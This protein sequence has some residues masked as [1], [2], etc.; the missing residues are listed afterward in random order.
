[1][2]PQFNV[3]KKQK[4][5]L[6]ILGSILL[7][8]LFV[9]TIASLLFFFR[10]PL[11]KGILEKQLE[12][13]T[14]IRVAIGTLDY[15]LFPLRIEAGSTRFQT[16]IEATEV[17]V[18][19]GR[20]VLRGDIHRLRKKEKPYFDTILA[21]DVRMLADVRIARKKI[22]FED[23]L[24]GL[25]SAMSYVQKIT[26]LNSSL[27]FA[28]A[29]Q[30]LSFQ[31]VDISLQP[32]PT[33]QSIAYTLLCS[34]AEGIL[35]PRSIHLQSS[36]Q[37]SGVFSLA[38][39]PALEGHFVFTSNRLTGA[40]KEEHLEEIRVNFN[41]KF[42]RGEDE[43]FF[44]SV[45]LEI[46][47]LL[48]LEGQMEISLQDELTL[49]LR[50]RIQ[51]DDLSHLF[52]R[53][54]RFLS[55][56][57]SGLEL[58][59]SA[60]FEGEARLKPAHPVEKMSL[61]GLVR[62]NP[63]EVEFRSPEYR[64]DAR[65]WGN[66]NAE[67][68]PANPEISGRLQVSGNILARKAV[69]A[70]GMSLDI[71]FVY[72][73]G[74]SRLDVRG[75]KARAQTVSL[76]IQKTKWTANFAGFS[77]EGS[78][79]LRKRTFEVRRAS[80][81]IHPFPTFHLKAQGGLATGSPKLL[82]VQTSGLSFRSVIDFFSSA[83]ASASASDIPPK[84]LDWEPEGWLDGQIEARF[85]SSEKA[86][87]ISARLD[88]SSVKFHDPSFTL[89]GEALHPSLT[90]D[91]KLHPP[92]E[93]IPFRATFELPRGES[94]WKDFY[95]DWS[96]MPLRGTVSSQFQVRPK[97]LK[98]L[99][100]G[101]SIPDFGKIS[102]SGSISL[103]EPLSADLKITAS[104]FQL[105]ALSAFFS[106]KKA[107]GQKQREWRGE[108]ESQVETRLSPNT[109]SILGFVKV[110]DASW[111]D[112]VRRLYLQGIEAHF[113]VWYERNADAP[114]EEILRQPDGYLHVE[115]IRAPSLE[116]SPLKLEIK[117]RRNG[118]S[119][120]SF[121]LEI[122]GRQGQVGETSVD[123]SS[124][125]LNFKARTSFS[126]LEGDLAQIPLFSSS[127]D[128]RPEGNL[129]VDFPLVEIS[130]AL[131][132]TEGAARAKV[133]GGDV[134]IRNIRV[135]KPFAKNRTI[136]CDIQLSG[137]DLEKVTDSIPFGRVTGVINGEIQDLAVAHGQPERFAIRI[138]SERRKGVP[139]RF[140][141]KATNDL[142]ILGTGEATAL[143]PQSG[144]T[145]FVKEFRYDKIGIACWLKNDVFSL[146]G[147][148]LE[149][150]VEYLVRG[151]GLF[152]IN[153]VNRQTRN[154]IRFKDM[155]NRLQRIGP[156]K[157]SP[158]AE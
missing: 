87:E 50:P 108:V 39:A 69:E 20:L 150:G 53:S 104:A 152:S 143:S 93:E 24:D 148:I 3:R 158:G 75:L 154:Q 25:S 99:L 7:F 28:F 153:V 103:S 141:L 131:I 117:G 45:N 41:G 157:K 19:I 43:F 151:K 55:R 111:R 10:K 36:V 121:T 66:F 97:K 21:E 128:F 86:W 119:I 112:E 91:A 14:G 17:D 96:K 98:D 114:G 123:F 57:F 9:I 5:A 8:L 71:P 65:L 73:H 48:N 26:L 63:A 138:E 144:W 118:Y 139:Q 76:D 129:S 13:R 52:H 146:R 127:P 2:C 67:K 30:K 149:N 130:P 35:K 82:S 92:G 133:F 145:R 156:S 33:E 78:F 137:L 61:R 70:R 11:V 100:V 38:E 62:L 12:K 107:G 124:R 77:G 136:S 34:K 85:S 90:L 22:A 47:S 54:K 122:F 147:T 84:L 101:L 16:K 59:G 106:Q 135:E 134:A 46:P 125:P 94:L 4:K 29:S 79:D 64:V 42:N 109:F 31:G 15:G 6:L 102:A 83:S 95:V 120:K 60:L 126:W 110:K 40:A 1:M 37:G 44:P 23:I 140:S 116:L 115:K 72:H 68:F 58:Q 81:D 56:E 27:E 88:A 49:L 105:P 80:A 18:F 74:Q 113:P 142:T 132:S 89:A 51:F 155:L 32:S